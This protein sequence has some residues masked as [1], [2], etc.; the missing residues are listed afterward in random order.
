MKKPNDK[1]EANSDFHTSSGL[2]L[3]LCGDVMTG[4]GIDQV[5]P[6]SVDPSIY[7]SYVKDARDYVR[8][9]E[10]KNGNIDDPVSYEYIWGDAM[11][12]WNQVDPMFKIINLETSITTNDDPWPGKGIHYRMHPGNTNL[13][14]TAGIDF[15]SL[16]NNHVLDWG[17][18]GLV[19]T[20]HSLE[21]AGIV[22]A[23]AGK[24]LSEAHKPAVLNKNGQR[25]ILLSYG[26]PTSG[27]LRNWGATPEKPGVNLLTLQDKKAVRRIEKK[28]QSI[29]QPGDVVV[30]S[31]HWG[32]N[33]G[34]DV[35][36]QQQKIARQLIDEAGVDIVHGHSS[37]HTR[38][39]E[40]YKDKLILY[41]AG[42]FLNDYEGISGHDQYRDD[43]TLMYFP[44]IDPAKGKL[45][46]M[47]M[48][49]MQ[50]RNF[51]LRRTTEKDTRWMLSN[52]NRNVTISGASIELSGEGSFSLRW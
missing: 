2:T 27:I 33:W 11:E 38:G 19:E 37:H 16:A 10:R 15:C 14:A 7:E 29:K 13:L 41:G 9:A 30:F 12:V 34:F 24:N 18:D 23:G 4:R 48:V 49:P 17:R 28:I 42:D 36:P 44:K 52:L 21:N 26:A 31:V 45:I 6:H 20:L 43:L 50:I 22:T 39:I 5:L 46:S 1:P 35:P 25:V 40:V 32:G 3:F 47:Q 51:S 8:L